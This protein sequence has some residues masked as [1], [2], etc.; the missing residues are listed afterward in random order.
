LEFAIA[1]LRAIGVLTR[2]A[3]L[4]ENGRFFKNQFSSFFRRAI[5]TVVDPVKRYDIAGR[6]Q[7]GAMSDSLNMDGTACTTR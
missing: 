5:D 6:S 3:D 7:R 4:R 2:P 1:A